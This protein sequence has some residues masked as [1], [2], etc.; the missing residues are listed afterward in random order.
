MSA[1]TNHLSGEIEIRSFKI[2]EMRAVGKDQLSM[3]S[4]YAAVFELFS[5]DLGGWVERIRAGAFTN[6]LKNDD[7]RALLNHDPSKLLGRKSSKTLRLNE[8]STGLRFEID[9]PDTQYARDIITSIRR[10][11]LSQ[12]SF[13]FRTIQ[14]E[15]EIIGDKIIRTLVE[16]KLYDVSPATF[17]VYPQTSA[18]VRSAF[19]AFKSVNPAV[20]RL[21]NLRR[22]L[23][24][25]EMS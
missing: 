1:N 10:G 11:D 15:W 13:A 6:T 5:D 23:D 9:P 18:S 19:E 22:R 3:I 14:D 24:L 25:A 21:A 8:D 12:M 7:V 16:L 20:A 4:G 2:A 17:P